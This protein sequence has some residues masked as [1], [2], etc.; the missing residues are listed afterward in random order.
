[1][2]VK[3]KGQRARSPGQKKHFSMRCIIVIQQKPGNRLSL[4]GNTDADEAYFLR[5]MSDPGWYGSSFLPFFWPVVTAKHYKIIAET[6]TFRP[7]YR[8][9]NSHFC[10]FLVRNNNIFDI[11][12]EW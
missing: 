12:H 6:S 11:I 8:K 3:V 9:Y 7:L 1:M 10:L 2:K 4:P 5:G